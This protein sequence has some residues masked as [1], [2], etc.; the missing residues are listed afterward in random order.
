MAWFITQP[1]EYLIYALALLLLSLVPGLL[2]LRSGRS[3]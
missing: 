2:L 3:G 1:V